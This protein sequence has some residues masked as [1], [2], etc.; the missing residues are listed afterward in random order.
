[1]KTL[2][3]TNIY[4][5]VTA[6]TDKNGAL[7]VMA[8]LLAK[9][10]NLNEKNLLAGFK[11]REAESSTGFG[12]GVAIP[13]AKID[14]LTDPFV[15]VVTFTQPV[16]WQSLDDAPVTIA[17]A[18]VMPADDPDQLHLK[19]LSKLARKLMDDDFIAAL[20][21]NQHDSQAL[22]DVLNEVL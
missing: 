8:G 1:M 13:H 17:I 22:A 6:P 7:G 15:G 16:A 2:V 14:G 19:V 3:T 10:H 9:D 21:K 11:Q 5:D 12:N 18:L 4:T 20:H